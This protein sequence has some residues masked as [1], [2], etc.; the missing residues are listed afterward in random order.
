[1][2]MEI[3]IRPFEKLKDSGMV[4]TL[5]RSCEVG[6]ST[7]LFTDMMGDPIS[8][9]RN[10]PHYTML[11]AELQGLIVGVI[12]GSI[13]TVLCTG[14]GG[15]GPVQAKVGYVLGLRVSRMHR[16]RGIGLRLVQCLEEWLVEN[17]AEY[18]YMATDKDNVASVKLFTERCGYAKFRTPTVLVNPVCPY[19]KR[20]PS[21]V[22]VQKLR[23]DQ[24]ETLYRQYMGS[25]SEFFPDDI[26]R[27]LRNELSLGT[28][29][30]YLRDE[31]W[32]GVLTGESPPSSWAVV[33]VWNSAGMFKLRVG[34]AP[35]G[36]ALCARGSAILARALSFLRLPF[37]PDV[38]RWFGFL[39]MYGLYMQGPSG[40]DLTRALCHW[41][42]NFTAKRKD[43][44][45]IVTE[46]GAL[47]SLISH[48]PHKKSL[49]CQDLWCVKPLRSGGLDW[50]R[51][52]PPRTLFV[53]P[54][55][56]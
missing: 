53:D 32:H 23:P 35:T 17:G 36:Y 31:T 48:V 16:R 40:G 4:E 6:P 26:D 45:V 18:A 28:W 29:I 52:H 39:F 8:R 21:W 27:V 1:M 20:I 42:H 44:R 41:V 7:T 22:R 46:L 2:D 38:F 3:R 19:P 34:N 33:S 14:G 9:V 47:D 51:T 5:E 43:C 25:Q 15:R 50:A 54:R 55:E 12:R 10:C 11:V 49:S 37:F 24:A 56:V 13:K 30:A